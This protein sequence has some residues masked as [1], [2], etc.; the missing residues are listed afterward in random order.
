MST[1]EHTSL[2]Q[3]VRTSIRETR[4]VDVDATG[5]RISDIIAQLSVMDGVT[6]VDHAKENDGRHDVW[7]TKDGDEFRLRVTCNA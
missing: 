2:K 1:R 3:D 5:C 6:D 4:I 7:G